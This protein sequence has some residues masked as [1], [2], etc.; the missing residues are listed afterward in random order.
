MLPSPRL[1]FLVSLSVLPRAMDVC[2]ACSGLLTSGAVAI[3]IK[4]IPSLSRFQVTISPS[5][6]S[7]LLNYLALSSSKHKTS[8]PTGPSF[9]SSIPS[10]AIRVVRWK[11]LVLDPST[12]VLR[13][14]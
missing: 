8:I 14:V 11:P 12:T 6:V 10:V 9:V 2:F 7:S 5:D 13:I 1:T 4:G 3:S